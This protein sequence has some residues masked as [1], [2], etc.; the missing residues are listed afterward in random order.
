MPRQQ[1][2]NH[3]VPSYPFGSTMSGRVFSGA[4]YRYG[5]NGKEEETDGTADNYD[6]GARIYDGRLGRW[7]AVDPLANSY[8][9]FSPCNF[10]LNN[11]LNFIDPDGLWVERSIVKYY[12]KP[13]DYKVKHWYNFLR[14]TTKTEITFKIH[15]MKVYF[16][17]D[18]VKDKRSVEKID[19]TD[20]TT[21]IGEETYFRA[22]NEEEKAKAIETIKTEITSAF[23]GEEV[24]NAK[25][26]RVISATVSFVNEPIAITNT[27]NVKRFSLRGKVDDIVEIQQCIMCKSDDPEENFNGLTIS[28]NYFLMNYDQIGAGTSVH[29]FTHQRKKGL[30]NLPGNLT[31]DR[32]HNEKG[33]FSKARP[34]FK[35]LSDF[36]RKNTIF[37]KVF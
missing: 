28:R 10:V 6:F 3:T 36:K 21:Y 14:K 16:N 27:K 23:N 19:P 12:G 35:N 25:K 15:N 22:P 5:F 24:W 13:G 30:T 26:T 4:A 7:L 11:P 33:V 29:E 31:G 1:A 9:A 17:G 20:G 18:M 34:N 32:D 2:Q 37:N 8:P